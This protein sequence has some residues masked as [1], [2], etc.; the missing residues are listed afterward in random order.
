MCPNR[1]PLTTGKTSRYF[2]L[3]TAV[4]DYSAFLLPLFTLVLQGPTGVRKSINAL[5]D[6]CSSRT[7]ISKEAASDVGFDVPTLSPVH[8]EVK[9]F[10]G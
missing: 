2:C 8:Y 6:S 4:E 3:S 7:Y 10:L 9:T 5:L 1:P